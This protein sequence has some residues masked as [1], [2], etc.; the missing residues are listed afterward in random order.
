MDEWEIIEVEDDK[1]GWVDFTLKSK[2]NGTVA[3]YCKNV[4]EPMMGE[5]MSVGDGFGKMVLV[6]ETF[7]VNAGIDIPALRAMAM[8]TRDIT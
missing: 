6:K 8:M 1:F 4:K 2:T 3:L 5:V 7:M